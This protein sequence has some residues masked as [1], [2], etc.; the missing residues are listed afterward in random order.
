MDFTLDEEQQAVEELAGRVLRDATTMERLREIEDTGAEDGAV[1]DFDR[2]LWAALA[3]AGLLG[4]TIPES[5][6]GLGLG[7]VALAVLLEQVGRTVAPVP[8]VA[9]LGYGVP[10]LTEYGSAEQQQALLP[11]ILEGSTIVTAA[12]IEPHGDP[13]QPGTT[14][15]RSGDGW[16]LDGT[17]ICV[18]AGLWA[19]TIVVSA[20]TDDGAAL[21][22]VPAGAAGVARE[23]QD[24]VSYVPEAQLQ[25]S[26]CRSVP[27]RCSAARTDQR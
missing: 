17:K 2:R 5:L 7:S 24:T 22:L 18:P 8:A 9:V 3:E 16:V 12:L 6:G 14:A 10:A 1:P 15:R 21:F 26:A 20:A 19:D 23:R 13:L 25:L 11:G 4:V 27:T